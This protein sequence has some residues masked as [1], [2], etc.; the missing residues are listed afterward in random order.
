MGSAKTIDD[1][2]LNKW[3]NNDSVLLFK[4]AFQTILNPYP[5]LSLI[6]QGLKLTGYG[7]HGSLN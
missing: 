2:I 3:I 6:I 7:Q 4:N 1:Y 5:N